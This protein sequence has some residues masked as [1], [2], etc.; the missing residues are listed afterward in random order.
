MRKVSLLVAVA[1]ILFG[2]IAPV[3]AAEGDIHGTAGVTYDTRYVWRGFTLFGDKSG[4]H[5][6]VDLDLMGTGFGID[7]TANRANASGYEKN[8]RWDYTLYYQNKLGAAEDALAT[9]YK[10]S[11]VYYNYPDISSHTR[12]SWDLQELNALLSW[13][14]LLGIK[15]LVPGYCLIKLWP[16]NSGTVV[17]AANPNGGT[18]SGFIHVFMLDYALPLAGLTAEALEQNLNFHVETVYND[19]V[20]PRPNGGY[21]DSDWTDFGGGIST[22]FELGGTMTFTPGIH[23]QTTM[24]DH[25]VKG[26]G[27]DHNIF[28]ATMTLKYKF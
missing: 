4:I 22:D 6:F 15:G 3:L 5:P 10:L 18:A 28:W 12:A 16:S 23:Y 17:G 11:Y 7:V 25:S 24:E 21:T 26:V 27:P 8:E 14:N 2:A 20:D 19:G 9:D 1:V 13:P